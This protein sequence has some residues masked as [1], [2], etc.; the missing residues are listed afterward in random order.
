MT[1]SFNVFFRCDMARHHYKEDNGNR[2][3][4]NFHLFS[5]FF[6]YIR[7][8]SHRAQIP[9]TEHLVLNEL[10]RVLRSHIYRM[11]GVYFPFQK[12]LQNPPFYI[13]SW[14]KRCARKWTT[15]FL[16]L[17]VREFMLCCVVQLCVLSYCSNALY[18]AAKCYWVETRR[19]ERN[20][21]CVK[22]A[23]IFFVVEQPP[24]ARIALEEVCVKFFYLKS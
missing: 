22:K 8:T 10:S 11:K 17:F 9:C 4:Q 16:V 21:K 23:N 2:S 13:I 14:I 12:Q 6:V 24:A 5:F 7:T 18:I 3:W 1:V 19:F 15:F 20:S